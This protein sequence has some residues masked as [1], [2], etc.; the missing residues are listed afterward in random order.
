MQVNSKLL[1]GH[2]V[3][4]LLSMRQY[5]IFKKTIGWGKA[6]KISRSEWI[7]VNFTSMQFLNLTDCLNWKS[8]T[9]MIG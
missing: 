1:H 7:R 3:E 4:C 8:R 9:I 2:V 6:H 5:T